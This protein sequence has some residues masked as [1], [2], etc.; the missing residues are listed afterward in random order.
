MPTTENAPELEFSE[1]YDQEHAEYYF[2]KHDT[3]FWRQLSTWRDRQIARKALKLTGNPKTVLDLPCG[4]GRFW[5][6]LTEQADREIHVCDNSQDMINA[7]LKF[8]P[9]DVVKRI[10]SDFQGSAFSLP[11]EDRF[12]ENVF[13]IRLIHHIGEHDARLKLLTELHRI[14]SSTVIISLWVD[15]NFKAWKRKKHEAKRKGHRYQN[16]F[17]IPVKTIEDEFQQVGLEVVARLDF[18]PYHSMWR[19]YVLKKT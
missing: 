16:R 14:T 5:G 2:H 10:T 17:V 12:V 15:G 4:T 9:V 18:I 3:G 11:V 8:R 13:C 1:K 19:T 7:G 6:V